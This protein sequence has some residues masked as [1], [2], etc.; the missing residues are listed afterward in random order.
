MI[1]GKKWD[2]QLTILYDYIHELWDEY[3]LKE[4]PI[5]KWNE[6]IEA[7]EHQN[8]TINEYAIIQN[9]LNRNFNK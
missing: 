7:V 1:Q 3:H 6:L 2:T 9:Y 4:M 5:E 8:N